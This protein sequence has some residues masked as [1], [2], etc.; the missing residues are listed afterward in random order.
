MSAHQ[1]LPLA[2]QLAEEPEATARQWAPHLKALA[3]E[4]R[5]HLALLIAAAPRTVKEL[6]AASGL[7]QTLV[8]YHLRPL[9]EQGLVTVAAEGR[10]N[11]YTLCCDE[12]V[13]L[14]G[15]LAQLAGSSNRSGQ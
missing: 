4:N 9:R 13:D 1:T 5:L 3:D 14:V 2:T 11:R 10:S 8:S 6:E 12:V 15:G 7:S